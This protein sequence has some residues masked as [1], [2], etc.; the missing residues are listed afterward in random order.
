MMTGTESHQR[1][2]LSFTS[3][4]LLIREADVIVSE[5]LRVQDWATVRQFVIK[6][7][8]LQARTTSTNDR[9]ARETIQRLCVFEDEE[10]RLFAESSLTERCHLMWAAA[11]RRFSLVGEFAEEVARERFLLMTPTLGLEDFDR[12]MTRKSLWHNELDELK[13]STRAR[14]RQNLF[15]MLHEAGLLSEHGDIIPAVLSGRVYE[16]LAM[17]RPSDVRFFPTALPIG[18]Q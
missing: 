17:R 1:Y 4:G 11:C 3:G 13:P 18:V 14:L 2:L 8:L 9:M 5:Y 15:Q 7:N 16:T 6:Q 10:L 12:F